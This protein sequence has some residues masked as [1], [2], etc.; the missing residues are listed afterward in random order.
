MTLQGRPVRVF[1]SSISDVFDNH[2]SIRPEWRERMW[3]AIRAHDD[4]VWML[5]TKR[6]QNAARYLPPDWGGEGW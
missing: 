5:L 1:C 6:P 2:P 4:L 3:A